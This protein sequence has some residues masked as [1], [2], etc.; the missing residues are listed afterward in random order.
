MTALQAASLP[1]TPSRQPTKPVLPPFAASLISS[2]VMTTYP[3]GQPHFAADPRWKPPALSDEMR[4]KLSKECVEPLWAYLA[5]TDPARVL[6]VLDVLLSFFWQPQAVE[7][8]AEAVAR[9][10][11][12]MLSSYPEWAI[13]RAAREWLAQPNA[14]R[15]LP[16]DLMAMM[17]RWTADARLELA[18]LQ[19][20]VNAPAKASETHATP[21]RAR[22][23]G[24][25]SAAH[26]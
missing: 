18:L 11:A 4:L 10:W 3:D 12:D 6:A 23:A 9:I 15:P 1:Q 19:R 21:P 8:T 22:D 24:E 25:G 13:K 5:P 7:S 2:G 16:G 20:L 17:D 14:R 26:A